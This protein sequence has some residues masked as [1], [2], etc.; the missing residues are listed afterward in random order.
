MPGQENPPSDLFD[1]QVNGFAGVDFQRGDVTR[2]EMLRAVAALR[3]HRTGR[4]LLT[5]ITDRVDALCVK[6]AHY[7]NLRAADSR[8]GEVIAGYHLEGPYLSPEPGYHGAHPPELMKAPDLGEFD[9]L[10]SASRGNIRLVTLAPE[11]PGSAEFIAHATKRGVRAAIGHSNASDA[12]I[13][14]AIA[15]GLTL[16]THLG[17]GVP[18][19]LPRHD[20]IVQRLL[21]RDELFAVFISD[22]V[23]VPPYTLRNLV[24]AK[25]RDKVLFTTD[26][27]AAAGAGPGRYRLGRL[28]V[29]VGADG[30]VREPGR[31]NLAGSALT[32]DR[33]VDNVR[34][35]LGWSD[36][37][38]MAAC[39]TRIAAV[40][41]LPARRA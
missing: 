19:V 25:P 17:N 40:L 37:D 20:N 13:D 16:C 1:L 35:F 30:V 10:W 15:A 41:G 6:L 27:M 33:A 32:M 23:H 14:A 21:A 34:T 8:V 24:R 4:I 3:T 7:E 31:P 36:A 5:L 28:E 39:S 12:Q 9:R 18:M 22:G 11:W 29:D 26:C 2:S 38:A